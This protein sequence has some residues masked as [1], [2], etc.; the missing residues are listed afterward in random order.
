[1]AVADLTSIETKHRTFSIAM[2]LF[3]ILQGLDL[4]TTLLVFHHGGVERNRIILMLMTWMNE[5]FAVLLCKAVLVAVI[6]PFRSRS[7]ILWLGDAVYTVVVGWNLMIL[8][9]LK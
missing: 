8:A 5:G 3:L 7:R 6:W 4:L 9:A 1:M 2:V